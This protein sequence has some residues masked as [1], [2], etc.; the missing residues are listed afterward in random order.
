L[1]PTQL[2]LPERASRCLVSP[3]QA[4]LHAIGNL[5][6]LDEP[7]LGL[8]ASRE[9]PGHVLLETLERVPEWVKAGRV[10]VSG[11]HS[12]LEQQ[13]LRSALRRH[14]RVVKVLARGMIDYHL[15]AE[16]REPL[17]TGHMLVITAFPPEVE[18]TRAS[19]IARNRL[20]AALAAELCAPHIRDN[21]PL[22]E[23]V[24]IALPAHHK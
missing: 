18:T 7:L 16:E 9:C 11:F 12:P 23:I 20:V 10:I 8:L 17:A 24:Q 2:P 3:E 14:G 6:L 1:K 13:V 19:A 4:T 22:S 5:A 21:S 15:A